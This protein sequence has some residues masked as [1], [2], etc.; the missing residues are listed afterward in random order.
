MGIVC[1]KHQG[2][3]NY[4]RCQ[5]CPDQVF[6]NDELVSCYHSRNIDDT[7]INVSVQNPSY[8]KIEVNEISKNIDISSTISTPT[9]ILDRH[10]TTEYAIVDFNDHVDINIDAG[11]FTIDKCSIRFGNKEKW[12][13]PSEEKPDINNNILQERHQE[14]SRLLL[15]YDIVA[16]LLRIE[17]AL[18][19]GYLNGVTI[20]AIG[21]GGSLTTAMHF[22]TDLALLGFKTYFPSYGLYTARTNDYGLD[23]GFTE[24]WLKNEDVIIFA[25]TVSGWSPNIMAFTANTNLILFCGKTPSQQISSYIKIELDS[26]DY[27]YVEDCHLI[28][29]HSLIKKLQEWKT[30]EKIP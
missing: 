4:D 5:F 9:T 24:K 21:N 11:T 16:P 1:I 30:T 20:T 6:H 26:S 8:I 19:E 13:L 12:G 18:I 17:S 3:A 14:I 27:Q 29:C 28:L 25:F 23:Q 7:H 22:L 2:E 15:Q 10:T